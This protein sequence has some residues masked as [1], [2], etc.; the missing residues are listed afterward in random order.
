LSSNT[1]IPLRSMHVV[2]TKPR[3]DYCIHMSLA[4]YLTPPDPTYCGLHGEDCEA[5]PMDT[6]PDYDYEYEPDPDDARDAWLERD[7]DY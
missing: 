7:W 3:K 5:E 2:D 6:C 4:N 1:F